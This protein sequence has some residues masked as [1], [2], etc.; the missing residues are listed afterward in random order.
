MDD[1]EGGSGLPGPAVQNRAEPPNGILRVPARPSHLSLIGM[2]VQWHGHTAGLTD[3]RCYELEVAVDEACTNVIRH[4]YDAASSGWISIHCTPFAG[5]LQVDIF[6]QGRRFDPEEGSR[7]AR[8]KRLCDPATGGLGLNMIHQFSDEVRYR[9]DAQRG[10]R[11]T[12][13]KHK[14][15]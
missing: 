7:V 15:G 8:Q 9:W 11:L 1:A 3:V 2:F 10:N 12:I 6:D 4:A 14:D 13:V 5:G